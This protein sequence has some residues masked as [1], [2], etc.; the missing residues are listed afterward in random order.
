MC[1]CQLMGAEVHKL[2]EVKMEILFYQ[3]ILTFEQDPQGQHLELSSTRGFA[4]LS[5][6]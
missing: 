1:K 3:R 2:Q 5:R 4:G 6:L